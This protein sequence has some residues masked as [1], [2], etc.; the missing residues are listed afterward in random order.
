MHRS[1]QNRVRE[2]Y[3]TIIHKH[4]TLEYTGVGEGNWYLMKQIWYKTP[5]WFSNAIACSSSDFP[6]LQEDIR[7]EFDD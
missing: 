3:Y 2:E 1:E 5:K 7:E 6:L 4:N